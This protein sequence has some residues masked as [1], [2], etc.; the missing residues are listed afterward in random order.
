M[1][2]DAPRKMSRRTLLKSVGT[3]GAAAVGAQ[4]GLLSDVVTP[5]LEAAQQPAAAPEGDVLEHLTA[6]EADTLKAIVARIIPTDDR[7]PAPRRR[8]RAAT[9]TARSAVH[10]PT[11]A[12]HTPPD[13]PRSTGTR[14]RPAG[15][16]F[17][18]LS[19][20][21]QDSLLTEVAGGTAPGFEAAAPPHSSR[22]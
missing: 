2:G 21:D 10:W 18:Q 1:S 11:R 13:L 3:A 19:A 8:A 17:H 9:S 14:G 7:G 15:A 20:A 22:W 5:A 6:A 12:R 4:A 16:P